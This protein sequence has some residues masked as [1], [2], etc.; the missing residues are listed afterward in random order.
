MAALNLILALL[1]TDYAEQAQINITSLKAANVIPEATVFALQIPETSETAPAAPNGNNLNANAVT[2]PANQRDATSENFLAISTNYSFD[3]EENANKK[4]KTVERANKSDLSFYEKVTKRRLNDGNHLQV[5]GDN[6]TI[7]PNALVW[8]NCMETMYQYKEKGADTQK[9]YDMELTRHDTQIQKPVQQ[10]NIWNEGLK[11]RNARNMQNTTATKSWLEKYNNLKDSKNE[12][13][14]LQKSSDIFVPR[15]TT[16]MN[17]T[18]TV[19]IVP[20]TTEIYDKAVENF[21]I[22]LHAQGTESTVRASH[23][24]DWFDLDNKDKMRKTRIKFGSLPQRE[25]YLVPTLRLEEGFYP[26]GFLSTLFALIHPFDFPIGK[27]Y[28]IYDF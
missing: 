20:I 10:R 3:G 16:V 7:K 15:A 24:E 12:E 21:N 6:E 26:F 17:V 22:S 13:R 8:D 11:K 14:K 1:L 4:V 28:C 19:L 23:S 9:N 18:T 2:A 27:L 5:D 25:N